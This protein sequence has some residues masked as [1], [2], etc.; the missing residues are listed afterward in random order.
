[1]KIAFAIEHF[2]PRHGGAEQYTWGLAKW[3]AARGH[4]I[5]IFTTNAVQSD[6][7]SETILLDVPGGSR[8]R[9]P[10][11]VAAAL[12][13]ALSGR[14]FDVVHGANHIWPCDVLRPG[15]GVHAAFEHYNALSEPSAMRRAIKDFSNRWLPRQRVLRENERQQF[16]DPHRRFIAVSQRVADDMVRFYPT[17]AGRVHTIHNGVDAER[18]SP[19]VIAPLRTAARRAVNLRDDETGLLFVSNNFRLKGLHDLIVALP[20][21]RHRVGAPVKLLIA[22]RGKPKAFLRLAGLLG[23]DKRVH[24]I[25]RE[26]SMADNYAAADV[27]VHPTY[28]DACANVPL[29]AMACGLPVVVSRTS[30][31]NELMTDGVGVRMVSMPCLPA[32]LAT[33]IAEAAS[34]EFR[35]S[36]R[37]LNRDFAMRNGIEANYERVLRLYEEIAALRR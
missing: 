32:D 11:R 16:G 6:F 7:P 13:T 8:A 26:T 12:K 23:V 31:A 37:R 15:G 24:F 17:C 1:M 21:L 33:A 27:L 34:P 5:T 2:D 25:A 9:W 29:E 22:G 10:L 4:A 19:E 18:F 28:Y 3:L 36:A 14:R 20:L 35:A 30:G